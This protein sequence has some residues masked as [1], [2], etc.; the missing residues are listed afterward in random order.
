MRL[1]W[2]LMTLGAESRI[3]H[4]VWNNQELI[5][6]IRPSKSYLIDTIDSML[7]RSRT[8]R[9]SRM[10]T[11][12]RSLGIPTPCVHWLDLE[13]C[14][15]VMDFIEGDSLKNLVANL[16]EEKLRIF[17]RAFGKLIASLHNGDAVHGDP[18]TSNVIVDRTEKLW[19]IDFGLSERNATIEMKGTDLHLIYR[20]LET[21]HWK[22]QEVMLQSIIEGYSSLVGPQSN[23]I[24]ER[25]RDIR[26]R[27]R[28][29]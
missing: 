24:L 3:L 7:R 22:Q 2:K 6:K 23:L 25:M 15:I 11:Y 4:G 17:C 21:T 14:S 8:S 29:H 16:R 13:Q 20:A 19:L 10:L 18:T 5:L 12:A 28:Y 1:N 27:G 9:E 26:E